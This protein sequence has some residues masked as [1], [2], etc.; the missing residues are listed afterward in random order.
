MGT[1]KIAGN[2]VTF[3]V[4]AYATGTL[5]LGDNN[6]PADAEIMSASTTCSGA[7]VNVHVAFHCRPYGDI[8]G[9]KHRS[10]EWSAQLIR[11]KDGVETV[12]FTGWL[13][14]A[15]V[16]NTN[17]YG[18]GLGS[19]AFNRRDSP[20]AGPVTYNLRVY[21]TSGQNG[22]SVYHRSMILSELKK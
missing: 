3:S 7:P 13:G 16:L 9:Y 19:V 5:N 8:D 2:A 12:V 18:W 1:A 11:V 14:Y 4:G 6:T 10:H 15:R 20:G 17:T 22:L 21:N